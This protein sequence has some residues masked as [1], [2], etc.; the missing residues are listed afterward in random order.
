M[1]SPPPLG[2]TWNIY[3]YYIHFVVACALGTIYDIY[4]STTRPWYLNKYIYTL[5]QYINKYLNIYI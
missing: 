3:L 4:L 5:Y 2:T 1:P